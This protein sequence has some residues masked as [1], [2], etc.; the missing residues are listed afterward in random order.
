MNLA[1]AKLSGDANLVNTES[2]K[3][4][5]VSIADIKRVSQ[6]IF[7]EK[8]SNVLYYHALKN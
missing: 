6:E 4:A 5:Q 3:I 2:K 8:N 7:Q 1:F